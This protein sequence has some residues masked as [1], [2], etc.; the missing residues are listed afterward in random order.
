MDPVENM[1]GMFSENVH[2]QMFTNV[3][4]PKNPALEILLSIYSWLWITILL[5][6]YSVICKM[7][8]SGNEKIWIWFPVI[9]LSSCD[10]VQV[11]HG[12]SSVISSISKSNNSLIDWRLGTGPGE[13]SMSFVCNI[14]SERT[15]HKK[16]SFVISMQIPQ[17]ISWNLIL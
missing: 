16:K 2:Y 12:P 17:W 15:W 5:I 14:I 4:K 7:H 1:E 13:K 6:Q 3:S 11:N 8:C 9:H 10:L